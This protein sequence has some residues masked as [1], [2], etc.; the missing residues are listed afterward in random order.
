[1]TDNYNFTGWLGA[2][3]GG[4]LVKIWAQ[5][6]LLQIVHFGLL[7]DWVE[8]LAALAFYIARLLSAQ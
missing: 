4:R 7:G 1:M 6:C 3:E 5:N 2:N 8:E